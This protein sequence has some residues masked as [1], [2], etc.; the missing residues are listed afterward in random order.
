MESLLRSV[1]HLIWMLFFL[2]ASAK[3]SPPSTHQRLIVSTFIPPAMPSLVASSFPTSSSDKADGRLARRNHAVATGYG[4][5]EAVNNEGNNCAKKKNN[6][7]IRRTTSSSSCWHGRNHNPTGPLYASR[8]ASVHL[9]ASSSKGGKVQVK[10]LKYVE[11]TGSIGDIVLVAPAFFENKLKRTNSAILI[12][13][14]EVRAEKQSK[15]RLQQAQLDQALDMQKKIQEVTLSFFKKAGPEGHLFGGV[16]RKDI[17][18]ELKRTFPVGALEGKQNKITL[19]ECSNGLEIK[20]DIKEVG[21]Y[22][23]TVSLLTDI[24]AT[25]RVEV[26]AALN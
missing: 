15:E 26:M 4:L 11:G 7:T 3:A 21:S 17:L 19:V 12:S 16:G 9:G 20:G 24:A 2:S 13:D 1:H 22:T 10:L 18:D 6:A 14:E 5:F 25:F 23:S 8:K